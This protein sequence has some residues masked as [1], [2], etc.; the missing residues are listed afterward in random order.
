DDE[1]GGEPP[2]QVGV[3]GEL[4]PAED[5]AAGE[6]GFG[7]P[8]PDGA[9]DRPGGDDSGGDRGD[10][11]PEDQASEQGEERL[12]FAGGHGGGQ[13]GRDD[14]GDVEHDLGLAAVGPHDR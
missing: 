14:E 12:P 5:Q 4:D 3:V 9:D 1:D 2:V 13:G 8:P 11:G 10:D 6:S 7:C